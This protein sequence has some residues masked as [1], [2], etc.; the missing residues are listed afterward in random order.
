MN[1]NKYYNVLDIACF[2]I[3]K[4]NELYPQI[5]ITN[6]RLQKLLYFVQAYFI[7]K[8][9]EI[10]FNEKIVAYPSGPVVIEVY[11]EFKKYGRGN[12]ETVKYYGFFS[13]NPVNDNIIH[14]NH[15]EIIRSVI[16]IFKDYD[17]STLID[18]THCQTPWKNSIYKRIGAEIEIKDIE[19]FFL[20]EG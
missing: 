8:Y 12:I 7:I 4:H 17:D 3:N 5:G 1:K 10:C 15:K 19:N 20:E 6:I 2:I 16:E 11:E 14:Y 13:E 9:K 18:I